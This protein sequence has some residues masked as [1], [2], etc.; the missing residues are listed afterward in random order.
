LLLAIAM[1]ELGQNAGKIGNLTITPDILA[2]ILQT[3]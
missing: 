1:K 2:T 3:R